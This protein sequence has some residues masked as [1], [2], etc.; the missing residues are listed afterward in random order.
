MGFPDRKRK[1][2]LQQPW[3]PLQILI[4][5]VYGY[6]VTT[7]F[8]IVL[9]LLPCSWQTT[10]CG[11]LGLLFFAYS[12]FHFLTM[13]IDP[14]VAADPKM[15]VTY[16]EANDTKPQRIHCRIIPVMFYKEKTRFCCICQK[17]VFNFDHH[18]RIF[19]NCVGG[20]NFWFYVNCLVAGFL[21]TACL[22]VLSLVEF[23]M[24]SHQ[25][26]LNFESCDSW[27]T[28]HNIVEIQVVVLFISFI[29]GAISLLLASMLG[30]HIC[31]HLWLLARGLTTQEY[32]ESIKKNQDAMKSKDLEKASSSPYFQATR[33]I[34][35]YVQN[36]ATETER[37]LQGNA[38]TQTFVEEANAETQTFIEKASVEVQMFI[39]NTNVATQTNEEKGIL[40]EKG[41]Q[42]ENGERQRSGL[43]LVD[44]LQ[45][46][47]G[48]RRSSSKC[49][50]TGCSNTAMGT[51][52]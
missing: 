4:G 11:I 28:I 6:L 50:A 27:L 37:L 1:N 26:W 3:H 31:F 51:E 49:S 12:I 41:T 16:T 13:S 9:P 35:L 47:K 30:Y 36:A 20:K 17:D 29:S 21:G 48:S 19:N 33:K 38:A 44:M 24:N 2:G 52:L 15:A 39:V 43:S 5:V 22:A 7:A 8:G 10:S 42:T 18:S 45:Q 34:H 23:S 25:P 14:K 40:T 32:V 46:R